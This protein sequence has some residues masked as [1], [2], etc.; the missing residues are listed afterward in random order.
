MSSWY[1][2]SYEICPVGASGGYSEETE[3]EEGHDVCCEEVSK[4]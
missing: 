1:K 4:R 3:G 2:W